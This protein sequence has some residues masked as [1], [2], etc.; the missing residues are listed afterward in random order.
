MKK[1]YLSVLFCAANLIA[2]TQSL[3]WAKNI[4]LPYTT[5]VEPDNLGNISVVGTFSGSVDFDPGS[6]ITFLSA[7]GNSS[8]YV[9]KLDINGNFLWAKNIENTPVKDFAFDKTG[10][11]YFIGNFVDTVDFD[12]GPDEYKLISNGETDIVIVKLDAAGDFL[13]AKSVGGELLDSSPSIAVDSIGNVYYNGWFWLTVDFDP[14]PAVNELTAYGSNYDTF[15]SKL[16]TDGN[17]IWVKQVGGGIST[18][19]YD[20]TLDHSGNVY[21]AGAYISDTDFDPGPGT[22][23]LYASGAIDIYILKLDGAGNFIWAKAMGGPANTANERARS[24]TVASNGDVYTI[25]TFDPGADFDPGP[26]TF[27]LTGAFPQMTFISKLD[28]N[29]NFLWAKGLERG[30]HNNY[31]EVKLDALHNLYVS[32]AFSQ[33]LDSNPG[34]G[35]NLFTSAGSS[36]ITNIKLDS[37]GNFIWAIAIGGSGSD[38][39][40][41]TY[42]DQ[43][44]NSYLI[45]G[46]RGTV[47]F[48]PGGAVL[49]LIDTSASLQNGFILKLGLVAL[50]IHL[51]YFELTKTKNDAH[52]TWQTSAEYNSSEFEI[53]RSIDGNSFQKIGTVKASGNSNTLNEYHFVD[54]NIGGIVSRKE[55]YYRLKQKDLDDKYTFSPVRSVKFNKEAA[56]TVYPNPTTGVITI[57]NFERDTGFNYIITDANGKNI[58]SGQLNG[59]G[60]MI[61]VSYLPKGAYFIQ[62]GNNKSSFKFIKK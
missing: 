55:I 59:I 16:D 32:G 38:F 35:T 42:I 11:M 50:P 29:G 21:T 9:L 25:G 12:P 26:G 8:N 47:D 33:T 15:I 3:E 61:D 44:G 28:S 60:N 48:D 54:W 20:I 1:F 49:N 22:N 14:G 46:F 51:T 57:E 7:S 4:G 19:C 62:L 37:A 53:E 5:Q 18:F 6:G 10:N 41:D 52:L 13:W 34:P 56:I 43:V 17:F 58:S 27:Y 23:I 24:I 40:Y 36:D 45:G 2:I 30:L 31:M 39:C